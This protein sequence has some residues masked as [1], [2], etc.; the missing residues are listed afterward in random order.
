M[1]KLESKDWREQF[2]DDQ[3]KIAGECGKK[4]IEL[5]ERLQAENEPGGKSIAEH[6]K[7]IL[8]HGKLEQEQTQQA[9]EQNQANAYQS[10]ELAARERRK[11]TE[12]HV[13]AI[14]EYNE[15]LLKKIRA[16]QEESKS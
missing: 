10:I 7:K 14:E 4:L 2:I 3:Q 9:L 11:A 5:G 15:I 16:N 1:S 12:E 6:G 8:Q 13:Q